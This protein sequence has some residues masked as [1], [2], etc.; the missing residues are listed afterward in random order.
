MRTFKRNIKTRQCLSA[1]LCDFIHSL[2]QTSKSTKIEFLLFKMVKQANVNQMIRFCDVWYFGHSV[3]PKRI[4][5]RIYE[6]KLFTGFFPFGYFS[7][8]TYT[9]LVPCRNF[10]CLFLFTFDYGCE[11]CFGWKKTHTQQLNDSLGFI[12][13]QFFC[14]LISFDFLW[15]EVLANAWM[16]PS[17]KFFY[18][19]LLVRVMAI[20]MRMN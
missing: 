16:F 1:Q 7:I 17:I 15:A 9:L 3:N 8:W 4:H 13:I 19:L 14:W 18:H 12:N 2:I 5:T 10:C 20:F 11:L 6:K